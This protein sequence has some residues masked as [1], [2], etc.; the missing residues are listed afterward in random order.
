MSRL[1]YVNDIVHVLP[2]FIVEL[3]FRGKAFDDALQ[4]CFDGIHRCPGASLLY[5]V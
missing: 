1:S 3:F 5:L 4:H 2:V